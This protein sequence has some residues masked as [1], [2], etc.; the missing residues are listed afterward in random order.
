MNRQ[1][2]KPIMISL[3]ILLC[4]SLSACRCKHNWESAT[5]IAPQT[6]I[7]CGEIYGEALGHL[8]TD[9]TC[10][11]PKQC[12]QC[13]ITHGSPSGHTPVPPTCLDDGYCSVCGETLEPAL[14]HTWVEAT[15]NSDGY[16][17][18]CGEIGDSALGHNW[19]NATCL[20][21]GY[22]SSCNEI[23]EPAFG[24]SWL[25]ATCESP[26]T[27]ST[28][29]ETDGEPLGH[30]LGYWRT[31]L[32]PT[33]GVDGRKI[34]SCTIC[35][36]QFEETIPQTGNHSYGS[37]KT[38]VEPKCTIAGTKTRSCWSCKTVDSQLIPATGHSY[39]NTVITESTYYKSGTKADVCTHCD[40]KK[41]TESYQSYYKT[42][43]S[44]LFN[45]FRKN[46][47]AAEDKY[48]NMY[49]EFTANV[50]EIDSGGILL[51]GVVIFSVYNGTSQKDEVIC[52][53][54]TKEQKEEAKKLTVGAPATIKGKITTC[55]DR[56]NNRLIYVDIVEAK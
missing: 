48:E 16:C 35:Q 23:G 13:G 34:T 10:V 32:W 27:C 3:C 53:L 7:E 47:L 18:N 39:Q 15:C 50:T 54:K 29:A 17:A 37:W 41:P 56:T 52:Q 43:L 40:N 51:Y 12:S 8:W 21:P 49:I 26:R 42:T 11:A 30:T 24:H 44:N 22:C 45:D 33:C 55:A 28:C 1:F 38:E 46:E 36:K 9:A 5:C 14:N 31:A 25:E 19:V 4:T 2:Y 20:E 6:C